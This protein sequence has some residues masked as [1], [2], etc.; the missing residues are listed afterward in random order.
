MF[1]EAFVVCLNAQLHQLGAPRSAL[2]KL[3]AALRQHLHLNCLLNNVS[4][5]ACTYFTVLWLL[6]TTQE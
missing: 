1:Y 3:D 4:I 2:D 6:N 5:I